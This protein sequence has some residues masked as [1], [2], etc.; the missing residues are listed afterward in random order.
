MLIGISGIGPKSGLAILSIADVA[1]I[2]R[3]VSEGD[4]SYLTRVSGIGKKNAQKIVL[5]L[6][7]KLGATDLTNEN[8]SLKD[9]AEALDALQAL[10]YTQREARD[11]LREV[12]KETTDAAARIKEALKLLGK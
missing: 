3:A 5:E 6:R 11:A 7:D 4:T 1:T 2:K 12:P 9:E 10:G 8:L